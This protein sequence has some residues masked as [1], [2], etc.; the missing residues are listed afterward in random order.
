MPGTV[1][2]V[3]A[4]LVDS[5]MRRPRLP[6]EHALL[7]GDRQPREERQDLHVARIRT[8]R[9][10]RAQ[11]V[12]R[13]A[14]LALAREEDEDVAGPFAPQVLGGA[15]DRLLEILLVVG[16]AFALGRD[17]R[18]VAGERPVADVH[19]EHASRHLDHR[20]RLAVVREMR[21]EALGI[22]RCR[23]HDDLE[24]G[25]A[26]EQLPQI[27]QQEVDVEAALV[28]LVDD[29]RVVGGEIAVAL[30][31]G[32]QDAVGHEL[33]VGVGLGVV[34]EADLV[35]DRLA[36]LR[37][38]SPARCAWPPRAPRCAAAGCGR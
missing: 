5:T 16:R 7:V 37:A 9:E 8:P 24:V 26:I 32:E 25:T 30:G 2:E 20:G 18:L 33:H 23:G 13:L 14:D 4:T 29:D 6:A 31:L 11:Q 21:G 28:R 15:H 3:S 35:A 36:H 17:H 22:D 19:R 27:A 1:S 38:P 12:A 34:A 10:A